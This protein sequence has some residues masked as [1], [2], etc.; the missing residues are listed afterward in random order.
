MTI[1]LGPPLGDQAFYI[2]Q[3]AAGELLST[4]LVMSNGS[5]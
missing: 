5:R 2:D 4:L 3:R 1:A